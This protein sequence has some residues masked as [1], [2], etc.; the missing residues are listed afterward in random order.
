MEPIMNVEINASSF[1]V[2]L[3]IAS[4]LTLGLMKRNRSGIEEFTEDV[5]S[6]T[7][8]GPPVHVSGPPITTLQRPTPSQDTIA[9]ANTSIVQRPPEIPPEGLPPGWTIEQWNYYGQQYLE[10][11]Q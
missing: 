9:Q 11:K 4:L 1:A 3:F 10:S 7:V 8:S 6:T 5:E 2:G